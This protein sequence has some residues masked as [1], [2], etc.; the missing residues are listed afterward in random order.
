MYM[1]TGEKKYLLCVC[2][3]YVNI[4]IWHKWTWMIGGFELALTVAYLLQYI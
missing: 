4:Y 1:Y 3:V 2:S